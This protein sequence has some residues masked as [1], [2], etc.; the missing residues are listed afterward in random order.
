[1]HIPPSKIP[2]ADAGWYEI[3]NLVNEI[4]RLAESEASPQEFH[5]QLLERVVE[6]LEAAAGAVWTLGDGAPRLVGQFNLRDTPQV[7]QFLQDWRHARLL[8]QAAAERE[9]RAFPPETPT[10]DQTLGNPT[11]LLLLLCP[12][13]AADQS[14][15]VLEIFQRPAANE[16]VERGYLRFLAELAEP[17]GQYYRNRRLR[18]LEQDAGRRQHFEEFA[19]RVHGSL[20]IDATAYAI[21][22]EG[23][24]LVGCDRLSV[25][26]RRGSA[27][28]VRAISGVDTVNRRANA[29]RRLEKLIRAVLSIDEPLWYSDDPT[30]LPP[31]INAPL[32]EYLD[33][34]H[35]RAVSV[36]PLNDDRQPHGGRRR[37]LGVLVV[38][39]FEADPRAA[40]DRS[41]STLCR[42]SELALRNAVEHRSVP[43]F[44]VLR[45]LGRISPFRASRFPKVLGV[46]ALVAAIAIALVLAPAELEI[47]GKGELQPEIR[48]DVFARTDGVVSDVRVQHGK[49][50]E[51]DDIVAVIHKPALDLEFTRVIGELST[52]RKRLSVVQASRALEASRSQRSTSAADFQLRDSQL[53]AEEEELKEQITSLEKQHKILKE[54]QSQLEVR[55]PIR[56]TVVTWDVE[57]LLATRPV[58]PG[59][60]LLTVADLSGP[61][62]LEMHVPDRDVGHVV[63]GQKELGKEL[64]VSFVLPARP[65]VVYRGRVEKVAVSTD[66]DSSNESTVL[67]TVRIDPKAISPL[68]PGATVVPKIHCGQK[69]VGYVWFRGAIDA[70]RT[71]LLF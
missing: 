57:R 15:T 35:A 43:F 23:R 9:P 11:P 1:M 20:D 52:A 2:P 26:V 36:I 39:R 53:A 28:R 51:K 54:Q 29:V 67:V 63:E 18:D 24:L 55:T 38:E 70:V 22:N 34:S 7:E 46:A 32:Q 31:Q 27:C 37:V 25:A 19:E 65:E 33:E 41:I 56:G 8:E 3:E 64:P 47:E 66:L 10:S 6:L 12:L 4:A 40:S 17:V 49:T 62:V 59:Q 45:F 61:W 71:R 44:R 48:R 30:G 5:A 42:Q 13:A 16:R 68:R 60:S 69:A 58:Q 50:V 21:A 14:Q